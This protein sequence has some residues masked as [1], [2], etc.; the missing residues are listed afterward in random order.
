MLEKL[1]ESVQVHAEN[2]VWFRINI[3]GIVDDCENADT[4]S[5]LQ[6]LNQAFQFSDPVSNDATKDIEASIMKLLKELK[7]IVAEG[8][9]DRI[10]AKIKKIS[11][12]LAERNRICQAKKK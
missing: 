5:K 9:S 2:M 12:T 8:E 4:K 11:N 10:Q 6:E 7:V 1:D 3:A